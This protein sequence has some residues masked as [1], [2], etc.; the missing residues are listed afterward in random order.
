MP[1]KV[2]REWLAELLKHPPSGVQAPSSAWVMVGD[3][4]VS[5]GTVEVAKLYVGEHDLL[6][7]VA[8]LRAELAELK[9]K[10]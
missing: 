6:A 4:L 7:E 1:V 10:R 2:G 8:A 9:A 3:R 5:Y